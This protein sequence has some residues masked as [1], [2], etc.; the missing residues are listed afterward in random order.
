VGGGIGGGGHTQVLTPSTSNGGSDV[1]G[2]HGSTPKSALL[3]TPTASTGSPIS[4]TPLNQ[5]AS[6][7]NSSFSGSGASGMSG[8]IQ[9]AVDL[10]P[11]LEARVVEK[12]MNGVGE[13]IT[14][15]NRSK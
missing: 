6:T 10:S 14:R 13:I 15:V 7:A 8:Q 5:I 2:G 3:P 1:S 4:I 11:D 12:S 9:I